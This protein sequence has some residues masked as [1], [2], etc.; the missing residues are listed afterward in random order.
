MAGG[1]ACGIG[2]GL[3]FGS[4]CGHLHLSAH[5]GFQRF[6][7][8]MDFL[9]VA[10]GRGLLNGLGGFQHVT[11]ML[12]QCSSGFFTLDGLALESVVNRLAESVPELLLLLALDG[13]ALRL[14]L[15][16][17][18]H[19]LDGIDAQLRL[20]TQGLRFFD[21]GLAAGQAGLARAGQRRIGLLHGGFPDGLDFSK[22]F[23]TQ[24]AGFAPFFDK[25]VQTANMVLPVSA[26]FIGFGP[27]QHFV[28]QCLALGFVGFGLLLDFFQ[29]GFDD[30]VGFVAGIVK[31]LPQ[32]VVGRAALVRGLPL[33]AHVAQRV[34]LLAP[35]QRLGDQRFGLDDQLFAN[36][37]GTPALPAF[38]LT[39]GGQRGVGGGL[40]FAVDVA[41]VFFQRMAQVSGDLGRGLAVAFGDFMLQLGECLLHG[42]RSF[43]AQLI[44]HGRVY[45]DLGRARGLA[46]ISAGHLFGF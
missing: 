21:H 9:R 10:A 13:H 12:T 45:F 8:S 36:L 31:T 28:N 17:L 4:G 26:V 23:I 6:G 37:V 44:E 11:V 29:P 40:Q 46:A 19:R 16:A 42:G 5:G 1:S 18:L 3:G 35:A 41:D 38:E 43:G 39:G 30:L 34:L 20:S 2:S 25:T 22:G 32:R 14:L 15:P 27:G 33:L 7:G 24:V